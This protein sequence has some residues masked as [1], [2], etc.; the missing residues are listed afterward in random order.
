MV[1][2][3]ALLLTGCTQQATTQPTPEPT[4]IATA[5]PTI[6]AT[7]A[8]TVEATP[9]PEPTPEFLATSVESFQASCSG[10]FVLQGSIKK[11]DVKEGNINQGG[12]LTKMW[13][14]Y[15]GKG[16]FVPLVGYPPAE[17]PKTIDA[18][19]SEEYLYYGIAEPHPTSEFPCWLKIEKMT[20]LKG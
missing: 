7:A 4:A 20:G 14:A 1:L 10:K 19:S 8:P 15:N 11:D 5:V 13:I 12:N 18:S 6:A 9:T 16:G 2:L 3:A 17:K